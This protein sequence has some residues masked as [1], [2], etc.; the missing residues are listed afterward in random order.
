MKNIKIFATAL[1]LTSALFSPPLPLTSLPANLP[2]TLRKSV[3][4]PLPA[5]LT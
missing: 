1:L 2:P 5:L 3:S 4:S